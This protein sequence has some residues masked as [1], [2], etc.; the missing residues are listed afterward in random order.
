MQKNKCDVRNRF[1]SGG[2]KSNLNK[3]ILIALNLKAIA[4]HE[5]E[6]NIIYID[7]IDKH[8]HKV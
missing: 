4:M 1:Y 3:L 7:L 2:E 6:L 8:L 5:N